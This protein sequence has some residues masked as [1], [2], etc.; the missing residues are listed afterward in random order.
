MIVQPQSSYL[1]LASLTKFIN[2]FL[3][4]P[5]FTMVIG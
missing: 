4:L 2:F 1:E 3:M 5:T